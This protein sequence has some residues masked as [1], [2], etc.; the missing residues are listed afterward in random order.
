M[1]L[2]LLG[3]LGLRGAEVAVGAAQLGLGADEEP[4]TDGAGRGG[5]DTGDARGYWAVRADERG[6][7]GPS[8]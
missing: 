5:R 7:D 3:V 1:L 8:A 2:P 4:Y 6:G